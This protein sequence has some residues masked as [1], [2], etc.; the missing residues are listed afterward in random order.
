M[1]KCADF[2]SEPELAGLKIEQNYFPPKIPILCG[3][4][5]FRLKQKLSF[6]QKKIRT[7]AHL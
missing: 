1:C 4:E 2:L 5:K 3:I 6:P 7:F